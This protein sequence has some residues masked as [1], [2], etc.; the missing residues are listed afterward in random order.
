MSASADPGRDSC[1]VST[2]TGA[3]QKNSKDAAIRDVFTGDG[4]QFL[5]LHLVRALLTGEDAV[6]D[7]VNRRQVQESETN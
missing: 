7:Y 4:E 5:V 2:G 6:I 3:V 1:T